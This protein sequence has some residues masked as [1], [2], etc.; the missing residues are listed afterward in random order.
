M[1]AAW[2]A[3]AVVTVHNEKGLVVS[4]VFVGVALGAPAGGSVI[5]LGLAPARYT[6]T[7]ILCRR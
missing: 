6:I 3:N 7:T 1:F 4:W 5:G 2:P